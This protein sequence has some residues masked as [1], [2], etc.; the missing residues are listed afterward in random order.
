[1]CQRYSA[2]GTDL[3][4]QSHVK[5]ATTAVIDSG[6]SILVPQPQPIPPNNLSRDWAR[7]LKARGLPRHSFHSLR[8][9]NASILLVADR[10]D[11]LTVSRRLGHRDASI[12]LQVIGIC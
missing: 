7:I 11:V 10:L 3:A 2:R 6:G 12:T 8:H 1:S 5:R 4:I 9:T